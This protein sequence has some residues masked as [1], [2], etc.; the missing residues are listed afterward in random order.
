[1][2]RQLK[3]RSAPQ[4]WLRPG[5]R[6]VLSCKD[7]GAEIHHSGWPWVLS[8]LRVH[9]TASG[10]LLDDFVDRTLFYGD[11]MRPVEYPYKM[12]FV[13]VF[14]HPDDSPE[15]FEFLEQRR[16][17]HGF[18][19]ERWQ[20]ISDKLVGAVT[21][22]RHSAGHLSKYVKVPLLVVKHPI[23][24]SD[25][26]WDYTTWKQ[27]R[28]LSQV[29]YY[30]RNVRVIYHVPPKKGYDYVRYVM[31]EP[32]YMGHDE[33]VAKHYEGLRRQYDGVRDQKA[34]PNDQYGQMLCRSVVLMELLTGSA[35]NVV[36]ECIVRNTPLVINP[37][38]SVVDYLGES[39][40]L[41][42]NDPLEIPDLLTDEKV[43]AAHEYLKAMPKD[44]LSGEHFVAQM[45][46]FTHAL[47]KKH[48]G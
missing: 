7:V 40:P 29:G 10:L 36:I 15:W 12:P 32:T 46:Q 28:Q 6:L 18:R 44:D 9:E 3:E 8:Q 33:A 22:S 31:K 43:V 48:Y 4:T 20:S 30:G 2:Q 11:N 5:Y 37:Y 1:M 13:G 41:Y 14:H 23:K 38:P 45:Q 47:F 42:F 16:L 19:S 27:Q 21:L 34:V 24:P 39:Y 17:R 35:N 25:T 26:Q